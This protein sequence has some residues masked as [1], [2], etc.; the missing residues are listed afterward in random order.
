MNC[1]ICNLEKEL[2]KN[3]KFCKDCK[4]E[5]E[6]NRRSKLNFDK[7]QEINDKSKILYYKKKLNVLNNPI[8]IENNIKECSVCKISKSTD[9]FFIEKCKGNIRAMCKDCSSLKRKEYYI[10]NKDKIIIQTEK[11][12]ANRI[13][14]DSA[15]K[16]ERRLRTRIYIAFKKQNLSKTNR[17]WKYIGCSP[18]ILQEWLRFQFYDGMT[19]EN[20]GS[21][22]HIDH[23]IPCASFNLNNQN[24]INKCFNWTNLRPLLA[25]KN[26]I[27]KDSIDNFQILMQE[28]KAVCFKKINNL[29][30]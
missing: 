17:T 22:W 29:K 3:R 2:A 16:L 28:L 7:K 30:I 6:R 21:L 23:V 19:M 25:Y 12:K 4:N 13:K 15:F 14:T 9:N 10:K 8:I 20:Y 18:L 27:K 26:K 11:Y 24:D 5:R 1:S